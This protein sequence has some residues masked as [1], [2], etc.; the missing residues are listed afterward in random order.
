M[1]TDP[2]LKQKLIL[3]TLFAALIMITF[4]FTA[5]P[6]AKSFNDVS[7]TYVTEALDQQDWNSCIQKVGSK[8][9]GTCLNY[10]FSEAK[11]TVDLMNS[12]N[13]KVDLMSC[14]QREND[15]WQ[16]FYR[17]DMNQNDTLHAYAC[18]GN[19]KYLK[20]VRK[21]GD[22]TTKFPTRQEVNDQY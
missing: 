22:F 3:G 20:W 11:Y 1:L 7:D 12:C 21:A 17:M 14:V 18:R 10:G 15:R 5:S 4:A 9:G 19:G 13:E 2:T 16:C 6:E 8:W